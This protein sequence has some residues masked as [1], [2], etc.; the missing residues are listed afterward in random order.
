MVSI[1]FIVF[2]LLQ[3]SL[4]IALWHSSA[5]FL[6]ISFAKTCPEVTHLGNALYVVLERAKVAWQEYRID[7]IA[8]MLLH[9]ED[10]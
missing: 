3:S 7:R 2:L 5:V 1:F 10:F 6:G 9:K 4:S 8:P